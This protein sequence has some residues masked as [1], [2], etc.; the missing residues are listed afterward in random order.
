MLSPQA[1]SPHVLSP[2]NLR[3]L[4]LSPNILSPRVL[5]GEN[6]ILE[7][8]SPHLLGGDESGEEG[9]KESHIASDENGGHSTRSAEHEGQ[10]VEE[11]DKHDQFDNEHDRIIDQN[12]LNSS[13]VHRRPKTQL[14]LDG[15]QATPP[16]YPFLQRT[17]TNAQ[18]YS[19]R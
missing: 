8:L 15:D 19:N 14:E 13:G 11:Q 1:I 3:I 4:V 12:E 7:V 17:N 18:Y 2:E 10:S 9:E 6:L 16:P 5:S